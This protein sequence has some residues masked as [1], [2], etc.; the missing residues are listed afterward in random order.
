MN[1]LTSSLGVSARYLKAGDN[2]TSETH[3]E[4]AKEIYECFRSNGGAYIKMGQLILQLDQLIPP[5]YITHFAPL[6]NEA[7][8]TTFED[9]KVVIREEFGKELEELFSEFDPIPLGSASLGQAHRAVIKAT[10]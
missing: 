3:A 2:V 4:S 7:P 10:G 6:M 9:V 8:L 5:E 1:T